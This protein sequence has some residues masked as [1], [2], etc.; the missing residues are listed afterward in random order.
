MLQHASLHTIGLTKYLQREEEPLHNERGERIKRR[1][2]GRKRKV[3]RVGENERDIKE[4]E[5]EK[6]RKRDKRTEEKEEN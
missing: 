1:Y 2:N 4:K 5:R 3:N 6:K